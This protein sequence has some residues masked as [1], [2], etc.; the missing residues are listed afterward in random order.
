MRTKDWLNRLD[1]PYKSQAIENWSLYSSNNLSYEKQS[2]ALS[3]A[4]DWEKSNEGRK[5]WLDLWF[6]ILEKESKH[7]Q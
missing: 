4:F 6:K 5:Y 2:I 1:E 3:C 7:I